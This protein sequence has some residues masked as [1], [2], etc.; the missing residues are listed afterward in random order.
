M[1]IYEPLVGNVHTTDPDYAALTGRVVQ[2]F[3]TTQYDPK[4]K[5][6]IK[7]TIEYIDIG[8]PDTV[9][10]NDPEQQ[11][12]T[13]K[14][15]RKL[16]TARDTSM[17]RGA[18]KAAAG[19]RRSSLQRRIIEHIEKYGPTHAAEIALSLGVYYTAISRQMLANDGT[20]YC[21]V[22]KVRTGG[23]QAA[24]WGLVGVHNKE[25]V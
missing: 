12:A 15:P 16:G 22:G 9:I 21:K 3:S 4:R 14:L 19:K 20:I 18:R 2:T 5:A 10:P 13:E 8:R 6:W 11:L 23:K 25:T 7:R 24:L 1:S 17:A